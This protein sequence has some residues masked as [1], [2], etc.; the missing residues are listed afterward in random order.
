[1]TV[2]KKISLLVGRLG[3]G[4]WISAIYHIMGR[5]IVRAGELS[6]GICHAGGKCP[7]LLDGVLSGGDVSSSLRHVRDRNAIA[8]GRRDGQWRATVYFSAA[9]RRELVAGRCAISARPPRSQRS[10]VCGH[11]TAQSRTGCS[12][13]AETQYGR[14]EANGR[15]SKVDNYYHVRETTR[16]QCDA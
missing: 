4:V 2:F 8:G 11:K 13:A 7:T 10:P 5:E 14:R 6:G 3:P 12:D 9:R 1:M 15:S 16:R